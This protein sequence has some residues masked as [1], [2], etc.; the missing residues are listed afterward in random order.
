MSIQETFAPLRSATLELSGVAALFVAAKDWLP[1]QAI[2]APILKQ[3]SFVVE[4]SAR[5]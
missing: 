4:D 5:R 2:T 3:D 1:S